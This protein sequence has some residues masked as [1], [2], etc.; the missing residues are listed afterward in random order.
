MIVVKAKLESGSDSEEIAFVES[1]FE[2][3]NF[4]DATSVKMKMVKLEGLGRRLSAATP[5][6]TN[7]QNLSS[8][9][10]SKSTFLGSSPRDLK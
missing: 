2:Q 5:V 9:Q 7:S 6:V 8:Q 3:K 10:I 4:M 1:L